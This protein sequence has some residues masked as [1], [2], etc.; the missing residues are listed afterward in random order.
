MQPV[1]L[2]TD[3]TL[4]TGEALN[5]ANIFGVMF[6]EEAAGYTVVNQWSAPTPFNVKG[7][8]SNI[9]WHFTDRYWNDFTE[10]GVVLLLD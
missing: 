4:K 5:K 8:Y 7:G 10:N 1:Y 3:G 2:Q 9:F 6:D